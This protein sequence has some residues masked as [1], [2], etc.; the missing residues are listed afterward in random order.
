[1]A[2]P[3]PAD[4][5]SPRPPQ[6][7]PPGW[8]GQVTPMW[9]IHQAGH[10]SAL[11]GLAAHAG[12]HRPAGG[13]PAPATGPPPSRPPARSR[14]RSEAGRAT[15]TQRR[16]LPRAQ[17]RSWRPADHD[18]SDT[19]EESTRSTRHDA[20]GTGPGRGAQFDKAAAPAPG[21]RGQLGHW[22]QSDRPARRGRR[23]N[24]DTDCEHDRTHRTRRRMRRAADSYDTPSE[25][26][27]VAA[28]RRHLELP[29]APVRGRGGP[30]RPPPGEGSIFL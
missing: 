4:P 7:P 17:G 27:D 12:F 16:P 10:E 14:G 22:R 24:T 8:S 11:A 5:W 19:G 25:Q 30:P 20:A 13:G 26:E 18:G 1:M 6:P 29:P 3:P 9:P 21:G 15:D 23:S 28:G 2:P